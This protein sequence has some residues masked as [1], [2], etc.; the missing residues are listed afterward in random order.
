MGDENATHHL[1][2]IVILGLTPFLAT[3]DDINCGAV[4]NREAR[5]ECLQRK[6]DDTPDCDKLSNSEVRKE[7]AEYKVDGNGNGNG[8]S[9]NVDCSKL[10]GPEAR[11]ECAKQKSK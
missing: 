5:R 8:N 11:R 6:Y 2:P 3:A 1:A 9:N 7:C 4:A 10:D